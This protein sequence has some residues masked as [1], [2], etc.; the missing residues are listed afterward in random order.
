MNESRIK[1][2]D[3]IALLSFATENNLYFWQTRKTS[4]LGRR[5]EVI[6]KIIFLLS[7]LNSK[8]TKEGSTVWLRAKSIYFGGNAGSLKYVYLTFVLWEEMVFGAKFSKIQGGSVRV[9]KENL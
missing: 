3:D 1:S 6:R 5:K 2:H 7:L 9:Q 4:N 8:N